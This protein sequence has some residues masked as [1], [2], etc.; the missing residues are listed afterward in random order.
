MNRKLLSIAVCCSIGW[1]CFMVST[2]TASAAELLPYN[3]PA[4]SFGRKAQPSPRPQAN[5]LS[6]N[7]ASHQ[8]DII[9]YLQEEVRVLKELHDGRRLRFNNAQRCGLAGKVKKIR[10]G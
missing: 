4:Q 8:Q 10:F 9:D 7:S 1:A 6:S 5:L 3:P 2:P